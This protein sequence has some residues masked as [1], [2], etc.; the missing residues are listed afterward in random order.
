MEYSDDLIYRSIR[1]TFKTIRSF[2]VFVLDQCWNALIC[3]YSILLVVSEKDSLAYLFDLDYTYDDDCSYSVD[4]TYV[5]NESHFINHSVSIGTLDRF[6][7]IALKP[8]K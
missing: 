6:E 7:I 4:A 2:A 8:F 5:G 3:N 1:Q